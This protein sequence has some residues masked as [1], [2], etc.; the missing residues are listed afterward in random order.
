MISIIIGIKNSKEIAISNTSGC[1]KRIRVSF[2]YYNELGV[3]W[4]LSG[5]L[6]NLINLF[7]EPNFR[8]NPKNL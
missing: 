1:S 2:S 7:G 5:T 6:Y 4:G 3:T 8:L